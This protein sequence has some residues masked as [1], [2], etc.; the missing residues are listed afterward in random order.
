MGVGL[1]W[2]WACL[3]SLLGLAHEEYE[4]SETDGDGDAA[5]DEAKLDTDLLEKQLRNQPAEGPHTDLAR[6]DPIG[7]GV[8]C[9]R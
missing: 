3:S 7:Y 9:G 4:A 5:G 6:R 2:V 1:V 8:R